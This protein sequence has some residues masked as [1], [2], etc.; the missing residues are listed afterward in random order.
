MIPSF[1]SA[2]STG[3]NRHQRRRFW[4]LTLLFVGL[5]AFVNI[6]HV[7]YPPTRQSSRSM[8]PKEPQHQHA[9]PPELVEFVK[10]GGFDDSERIAV[11]PAVDGDGDSI[12]M[13][14]RP[15]MA[16]PNSVHAT[17]RDPSNM[18]EKEHY[19]KKQRYHHK[20]KA[21]KLL[22]SMQ[23]EKNQKRKKQR[24]HKPKAKQHEG[25]PPLD[26]L[27]NADDKIS[28]SVDW[29][30]DFAILGHAKCATTYLMNWLRQHDSVQMHDREVCDLNNRQ[31][32][33]LVR[34]LYTELPAGE[35][36]VRGYK[37]PG[38]FSREPLR[39]FRQYFTKTK[40]IVGLRHPVR[41]FER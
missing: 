19:R 20:V 29:L 30:L 39:Y 13:T 23:T 22:R 31:P 33:S 40:L 7:G 2:V 16:E 21:D 8:V 11:E 10:N 3:S 5:L 1:R 28:G 14:A 41:W 38:H 37:C 4:A 36:F 27:V 25:F 24:Y 17:S 32:A 6:F 35:D 26:R 12:A 15:T 34:K 9:R 18:N